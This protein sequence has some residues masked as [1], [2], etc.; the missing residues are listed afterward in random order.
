MSTAISGKRKDRLQN[1]ERDAPPLSV[2]A[3]RPQE[4]AVTRDEP[5]SFESAE[6]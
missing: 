6:N 5:R 3:E 4:D 1:K 2:E